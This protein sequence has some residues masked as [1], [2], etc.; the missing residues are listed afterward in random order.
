MKRF[1]DTVS[2]THDDAGWSILLDDRPVRTP[3]R[4]ALAVPT[5]TLAD[6]I[7]QEWREQGETI[8]P[9]SMRFTGLA[10]AAIDRIA[11]DPVPYITDIARYAESDLFCYR[12]IEPEPLVARQIATWNPLLDWAERRYEVEFIITQG[13]IPVNQPEM[14][15]LRLTEAVSQYGAFHLAALSILTTIGG[16]LVGALAVTENHKSAADIWSAVSIDELWQEEMWG[17]DADAQ[18][19]RAF[20][21]AEWNDAAEFLSL[22]AA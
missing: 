2:V 1:Y 22:L 18:K 4:A 8:D 13:I 6:R 16:S 20:H 5:E 14:T 10:N 21:Q 15:L 17:A 12:A 19:A 7:A 3:G 11:P 9:R